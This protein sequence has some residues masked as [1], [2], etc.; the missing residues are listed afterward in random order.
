MDLKNIRA[1]GPSITET[2]FSN[3]V[4]VSGI[5]KASAELKNSSGRY[6][7]GNRTSLRGFQSEMA[8]A[9]L[10]EMNHWRLIFYRLK[11]SIAEVDLIFEKN[12]K[13]F[14]LNGADVFEVTIN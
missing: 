12:N 1:T 13:I 3:S 5:V 11:T 7:N 4:R 6:N 10:L 8:V 14:L 9:K 2:E